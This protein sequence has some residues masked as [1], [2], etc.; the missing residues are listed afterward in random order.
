MRTILSV[1]IAVLVA[2]ISAVAEENFAKTM[3]PVTIGNVADATNW[4][5]PFITWGGDVATFMAN[6]GLTTAPGSI[7]N[8]QG[9]NIKLTPGD[10]FIAQVRDYM[11]GKSPFLRAPFATIGL[12]TEVI[13]SDPR[14]K[15]VVVLQETWSQGD[16]LV[17]RGDKLKTIADLKG[18]DKKVK[19]VLQSY[20]PHVGML[21]TI[22]TST[23]LSWDDIEVIWAKDLTNSP[24][25]PVAMFR[26]DAS[27]DACFVITPDMMGL[28]GDL[29]STGGNAEGNVLGSR[30]LVSTAEL[31]RSIADMIVCRKDF[32]DANTV[33]VTKFVAGYMKAS[34]D[35]LALKKKYETS[36]SPEYLKVLK[37]TQDIYGTETIPTLENDAHGLV[38]DANFV[39]YPGN[40]AFFTE[41]GNLNGFDVLSKSALDLATSRGYASVRC[42]LIPAVI[43]YS[44]PM[45]VGYLANTKVERQERFRAE[46][47][48]S[49]IEALNSGQ[50]DEKKMYTFSIEFAPDQDD[51]SIEQYGAEFKQA[52]EVASKFGNAVLAIRG[53]SD[54]SL[55]LG[56]FVKAGLAKGILKQSGTKGNYSYF[57]NGKPFSL[58][59]TTEIIAQIEAGAFDGVANANPRQTMAAAL[60]KS[61]IRAEKVR[62][63]IIKFATDNGLTID[64][65]QIQP[66]GVGIIEP[67]VTKPKDV[68]EAAPNRRVEISIVQVSAEATNDSD[69]NF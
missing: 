51:F 61:K 10:D 33:A 50:L 35:L 29:R 45:F 65:S 25:S 47:V 37:M 36:G 5:M 8:K 14:T 20:G 40:V 27:I 48:E 34:E 22:L 69:F 64:K 52:I 58:D 68:K 7:M 16:H 44:T 39:G 28:C 60:N 30:V 59:A 23:G 19:I 13:G 66:F 63:S 54:L 62:A 38:C 41:K 31:S 46:A 24:N 11:T 32:Y 56:D 15:G 2:A 55:T 49:E 26:K 18:K 57:Y 43:D 67:L 17:I 42:A 9:L 12:V 4:N 1:L 6:G 21:D 3:G 53:H